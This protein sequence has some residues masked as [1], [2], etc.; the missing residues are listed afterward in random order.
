MEQIQHMNLTEPNE[1]LRLM[2]QGESFTL[3]YL[4]NNCL[5]QTELLLGICCGVCTYLDEIKKTHPEKYTVIRE[6]LIQI[7][8]KKLK[9]GD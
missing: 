9:R 4:D 3:E 2:A 6:L 7:G 8:K 5:N 1:A